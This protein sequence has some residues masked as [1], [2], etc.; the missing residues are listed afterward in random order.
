MK[1]RQPFIIPD[2]SDHP[3]WLKEKSSPYIR[4]WIGAPVISKNRV[5]AFICLDHSQPNFYKSEHAQRLAI[6]AVQASMT[7][8]NASLFEEVKQWATVDFL[9]GLYN[10]RH[11]FTL[12]E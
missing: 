8:E 9:T 3:Y 11:F 5:V 4:S 7:M 10:R 12:A 1:T 6:F 2:T